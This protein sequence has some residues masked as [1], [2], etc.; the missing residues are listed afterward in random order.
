MIQ[1]WKTV[2]NRNLI[3]ESIKSRVDTGNA[4]YRSIP[5][6]MPAFLLTEELQ[7]KM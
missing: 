4:C 7:V 6:I 1:D 3:N 5:N 2:A